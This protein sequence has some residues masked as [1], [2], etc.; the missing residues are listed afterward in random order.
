MTSEINRDWLSA[1]TSADHADV[2][3]YRDLAFAAMGGNSRAKDTLGHIFRGANGVLAYHLIASACADQMTDGE[4]G[5]SAQR[6]EDSIAPILKTPRAS[7]ALLAKMTDES[8]PK[9][10]TLRINAGLTQKELATRCGMNIRQ[11]Q[12]IESGEIKL[13]NTILKNAVALA[14]ALGVEIKELL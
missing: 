13:Q 14:D 10:L 7:D 1:I 12:K 11:I 9:L 6:A 8:A 5:R 3:A 2:I 4:I